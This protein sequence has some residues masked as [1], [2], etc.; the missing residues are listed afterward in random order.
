[1]KLLSS[2]IV[3]MNSYFNLNNLVCAVNEFADSQEYAITKKRTK[4][5]KKKILRKA[6]LKCDKRKENKL[7][8]FNKRET[9]TR[10]CDCSFEAV[11]ILNA[12]IER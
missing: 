6:V 5:S 1:M 8:E 11:A 3:V 2:D 7:K 9:S 12:E 10:Q 4:V